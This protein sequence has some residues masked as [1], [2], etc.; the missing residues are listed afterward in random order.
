MRRDGRL[1]LA[2]IC[3]ECVLDVEPLICEDKIR[4]VQTNLSINNTT[5]ANEQVSESGAEIL[6]INQ[7][8]KRKL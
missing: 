8:M 4:P 1:P 5:D 3:D 7:L 2:L 6:K